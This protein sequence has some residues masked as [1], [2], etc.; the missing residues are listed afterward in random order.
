MTRKE[1]NQDFLNL[2]GSLKIVGIVTGVWAL[3][4]VLIASLV[5]YAD[6][7][8]FSIFRTYLSDIGDTSGWPQ[9]IFNSGTLISAPLRY[10]ILVLV[11]LRLFNL[12]MSRG[13]VVFILFI[14]F[15]SSCGTVFMTAVPFHI[16]PSIHKTGIALYFFGTVFLQIMIFLVEWSI[17]Q[18]PRILSVVSIITALLFIVF[19]IL[20]VL[21]LKGIV[22]RDTPVF[23][24]WMCFVSSITWVFAHSIVLGKPGPYKNKNS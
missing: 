6:H 24:E 19:A 9:I 23:W 21:S 8:D 11:V 3:S 7:P 20:L 12:G 2:S 15:L 5:Y 14:G 16:A 4:F 17:K 13:I 10:L 18:I 22:S 1:N